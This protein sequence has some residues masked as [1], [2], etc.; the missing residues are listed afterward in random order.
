VRPDTS[1]W[2]DGRR[3]EFFDTLSVEGLAWEC[4][5]RFERYQEHYGELL[6]M[7][8]EDHPYSTDAQRHWGLRF[9][10]SSEPFRASSGRPMVAAR[11][12]GGLAH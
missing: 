1:H 2:R 8:A 9:P 11:Q 12:S 3:Y 10:G 7:K 6:A 4:L 5:R